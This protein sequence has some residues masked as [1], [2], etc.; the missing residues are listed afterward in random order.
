MDVISK[1]DTKLTGINLKLATVCNVCASIVLVSNSFTHD[2]LLIILDKILVILLASSSFKFSKPFVIVK[3]L[4]N[5][6]NLSYLK[7]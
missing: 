5:I 3:L 4:V 6:S 7:Y 1:K 2:N